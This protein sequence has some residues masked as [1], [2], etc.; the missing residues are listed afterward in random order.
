MFES[1]FIFCICLG[2][3]KGYMEQ[4]LLDSKNL[5]FVLALT[6]TSLSLIHFPCIIHIPNQDKCQAKKLFKDYFMTDL[7][8]GYIIIGL[9]FIVS[10]TGIVSIVVDMIFNK[11]Q[12]E[13]TIKRKEVRIDWAEFVE[14]QSATL[15]ES[16]NK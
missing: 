3:L 11:E 7:E 4:Q 2:L 6:I 14:D 9:L 10:S 1:A 5:L 16:V 15:R 12:K 13:I 8:I